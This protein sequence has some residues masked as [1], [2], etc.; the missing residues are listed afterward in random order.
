MNDGWL[1]EVRHTLKDGGK[2]VQLFNVAVEDQ[3]AAETA[4]RN[5]IHGGPEVEVAVKLKIPAETLV[6]YGLKKNQV[7]AA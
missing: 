3:T 1:V 5:F 7:K 4:V 6:R 2:L